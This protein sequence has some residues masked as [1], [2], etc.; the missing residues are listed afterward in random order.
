VKKPAAKKKKKTKAKAKPAEEPAAAAEV[1]LAATV[2][3]EGVATGEG[4]E[5]SFDKM[6]AG[7]LDG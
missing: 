7:L 5:E 3:E 4:E 1:A 6:L 2:P